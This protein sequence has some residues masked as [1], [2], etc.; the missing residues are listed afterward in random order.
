MKAG[1]KSH[2]GLGEAP[3]G[4]KACEYDDSR[5]PQSQ[6]VCENFIGNGIISCY[7]CFIAHKLGYFMPM[8]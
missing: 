4:N 1:E 2:L 3:A 5:V 6:D 7:V 8:L